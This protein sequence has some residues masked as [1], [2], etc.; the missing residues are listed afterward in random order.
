MNTFQ[1]QRQ[2]QTQQ[3]SSFGMYNYQ[4]QLQQGVQRMGTGQFEQKQQPY[5]NQ[6]M[7]LLR[8]MPPS[9]PSSSQFVSYNSQSSIQGNKNFQM[10]LN[11]SPFQGNATPKANM[12]PT[13]LNLSNNPSQGYT[14]TPKNNNFGAMPQ[15]FSNTSI[16]MNTP[17]NRQ[18]IQQQQSQ[19]AQNVAPPQM[20]QPSNFSSSLQ[21]DNN[22][23]QNVAINIQNSTPSHFQRNM[24]QNQPQATPFSTSLYPQQNSQLSKFNSNSIKDIP[25]NG[26]QQKKIQ[27]IITVNNKQQRSHSRENDSVR[28]SENT[29]HQDLDDIEVVN[30]P[31]YFNT[32]SFQA[33][34]T[35]LSMFRKAQQRN[36][37]EG[38]NNNLNSP[39]VSM[40]SSKLRRQKSFYKYN[41]D[42]LPDAID[43]KT[44]N[45]QFINKIG[46]KDE[47]TQ[48]IFGQNNEKRWISKRP[49]PKQV[50]KLENLLQLIE[51]K[52]GISQK[53]G[54]INILT[55]YTNPSDLKYN[56]SE[57]MKAQIKLIKELELAVNETSLTFSN[58]MLEM[59]ESQKTK[60]EKI[61]KLAI[62]GRID[63]DLE[64]QLKEI[65]LNQL[66]N[67]C[68]LQLIE[69]KYDCIE[70]NGAKQTEEEE[71][72][73]TQESQLSYQ[74]K[75]T[76]ELLLR[77]LADAMD[78]CETARSII[79]QVQDKD[80]DKTFI[81]QSTISQVQ[82]NQQ[83]NLK[84]QLV[85][86][87]PLDQVLKDAVHLMSQSIPNF[88]KAWDILCLDE[89]DTQN[90]LIDIQTGLFNL[91][92]CVIYKQI[93]YEPLKKIMLKY[94]CVVFLDIRLPMRKNNEYNIQVF[95][96]FI[97]VLQDMQEDITFY[98]N[99]IE[100]TTK[101]E[102]NYYYSYTVNEELTKQRQ[103]L[104][105]LQNY[106]KNSIESMQELKK[107]LS[108]TVHPMD[109]MSKHKSTIDSMNHPNISQKEIEYIFELYKSSIDLQQQV[110]QSLLQID[111]NKI[112]QICSELD[113]PY[114]HFLTVLSDQI[115]KEINSSKQSLKSIES[116]VLKYRYVESDVDESIKMLQNQGLNLQKQWEYVDEGKSKLQLEDLEAFY[117]QLKET[118]ESIGAHIYDSQVRCNMSSMNFKKAKKIYISLKAIHKKVLR[119]L[120]LQKEIHLIDLKAFQS[121]VSSLDLTD[122]KSE[123]EFKKFCNMIQG[124]QT[125]VSIDQD[126]QDFKQILDANQGFF[127]LVDLY[128]KKH[129]TFKNAYEKVQDLAKL[130]SEYGFESFN[131]TLRSICMSDRNLQKSIN[132]ITSFS[133]EFH[134]RC[135]E[136]INKKAIEQNITQKNQLIDQLTIYK[137]DIY[138]RIEKFYL[139]IFETEQTFEIVGGIEN[140]YQTN[141]IDFQKFQDQI[142]TLQ[143]KFKNQPLHF[144]LLDGYHLEAQQNILLTKYFIGLNNFLINQS[145]NLIKTIMPNMKQSKYNNSDDFVSQI[146]SLYTYNAESKIEI[147]LKKRKNINIEIYHRFETIARSFYSFFEYALECNRIRLAFTEC[148]ENCKGIIDLGD[149]NFI[150][151]VNQCL[152]LSTNFDKRMETFITEMKN[153][154]LNSFYLFSNRII[155]KLKN[156]VTISLQKIDIKFL[157]KLQT[158]IQGD[159]YK[160]CHM[161]YTTAYQEVKSYIQKQQ[162]KKQ[163]KEFLDD[164]HSV[165]LPKVRMSLANSLINREN[166]YQ[167]LPELK[168]TEMFKEIKFINDNF[169]LHKHKNC[170][171]FFNSLY[172]VVHLYVQQKLNLREQKDLIGKVSDLFQKHNQNFQMNLQRELSN[173]FQTIIRDDYDL[174]RNFKN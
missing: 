62:D 88:R 136:Q 153:S 56:L 86:D 98:L 24:I 55:R 106:S 111:Q 161:N 80:I 133:Q 148:F 157:A 146:Q 7:N 121:L 23:N 147:Y 46:D 27:P 105:F 18:P 159:K 48:T 64:G 132:I 65:H 82:K 163:I 109:I 83:D 63:L 33:A 107:Q 173:L 4:S 108:E 103:F 124:I 76:S 94:L 58:Q 155:E 29:K 156:L 168:N 113:L 15:V 53:E 154:K 160:E 44:L 41:K 84:S 142:K 140:V 139:F 115:Q 166:F 45:Y 67:L 61:R 174:S 110:E 170:E 162:R 32:G 150:Q 20:Y 100:R 68:K 34:N 169:Q 38:A 99:L 135:I 6:D 78:L 134:K 92:Q 66:E 130:G 117:K 16:Q 77:R 93:K 51:T 128:M 123:A 9:N 19:Y 95:D 36:L 158:I 72:L 137:N 97:K 30:S 165:Y 12:Q 96:S 25:Q 120:F 151:N 14:N 167:F 138:A 52:Y 129:E 131:E 89:Q 144:Q 104:E 49:K 172:D 101:G 127:Q 90:L 54:C 28:F 3:L 81:R 57:R 69:Y 152:D 126:S 10:N 31:Q 73:K 59:I 37:S 40:L 149:Q 102:Q 143:R 122:T 79:S 71:Q 87:I 74:K 13:N 11:S 60:K 91:K 116:Y 75:I 125:M 21:R 42:M 43:S 17:L 171:A 70:F 5:Q 114:D 85:I 35:Q 145:N 112:K 47:Q 50:K 1:S 8:T 2:P 118:L 26:I 22:F 164:L 119:N 141:K 39:D